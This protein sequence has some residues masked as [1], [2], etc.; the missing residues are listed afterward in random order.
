MTDPYMDSGMEGMLKRLATDNLWRV[1][2]HYEFDDLLQELH[3]CYYRCH[4]RYVG[5]RPGL[6]PNGTRRRSLPAKRPD[7]IAIRHFTR[8]VQRACL[9]LISTMA[10]KNMVS[11]TE[12]P[13]SAMMR[14][15]DLSYEGTMDRL[16]P[17]EPEAASC[18]AMLASAPEEL[19]E[20]SAVLL[21]DATG[22]LK[23][24]VREGGPAV[25]ET[26]NQRYCR[27]LGCD[28]ADTDI[29]GIVQQYFG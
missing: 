7:G 18:L 2:A 10:K 15:D 14:S 5:Q 27:L 28:P 9:N 19:R 13:I 8:I 21:S 16:L 4:A 24:A 25:R 1:A 23:R 26:T 12:Q 29:R 11:P 6:R 20:L 17:Q 3:I 22:F